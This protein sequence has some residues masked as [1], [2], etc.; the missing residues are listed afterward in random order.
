MQTFHTSFLL[1]NNLCEF[2]TRIHTNLKCDSILKSWFKILVL[3]I[4]G[5][6]NKSE[7]K[8]YIVQLVSCYLEASQ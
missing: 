2:T 1:Q 4:F 5:K 8:I 6:Q 7:S 3:E